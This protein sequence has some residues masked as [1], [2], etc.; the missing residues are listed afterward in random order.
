MAEL[1][2][3]AMLS[4]AAAAASGSLAACSE[5][6]SSVAA[7][8]ATKRRFENKVIVITGATLASDVPAAL[9]FA[10]EGARS[11]SAAAANFRA[12]GRTGDSLPRR[13]SLLH[14]SRRSRGGR[15]QIICRPGCQRYG[16]LDV[17]FNNAGHNPGA[18]VARVHLAAMDDV[19]IP[20]CAASFSP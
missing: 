2:R 12:P 11:V 6:S 20:T 5:A 4:L 3:R 15:S 1:N 19:L 14:Q 17:A 9:A 13:R 8:P 16:R 18:A 10:A 7:S